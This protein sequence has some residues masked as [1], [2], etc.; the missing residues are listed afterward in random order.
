MDESAFGY[1][2]NHTFWTPPNGEQ[3]QKLGLQQTCFNALV[4]AMIC[5]IA[6]TLGKAQSESIECFMG[7]TA[8]LVESLI[9]WVDTMQNHGMNDTGRSSG[10]SSGGENGGPGPNN[11]SRL[12]QSRKVKDIKIKAFKSE[13]FVDGDKFLAHIWDQFNKQAVGDY[14]ENE[15]MCNKDPSWSLAFLT[16]LRE[17]IADHKELGRLAATSKKELCK[18]FR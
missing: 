5:K 8:T 4:K 9:K 13:V 3:L 17:S 2:D 11:G 7:P 14:L 12:S 15:S 16:H 10:Q 1:F 6:K 18:V